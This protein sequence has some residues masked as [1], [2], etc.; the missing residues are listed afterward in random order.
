MSF[1]P[2]SVLHAEQFGGPSQVGLLVHLGK[3]A[4]KENTCGRR[5]KPVADLYVWA[6]VA[7]VLIAVDVLFINV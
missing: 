7:M 1:A 2:A 6:M 5:S 4:E 3:A